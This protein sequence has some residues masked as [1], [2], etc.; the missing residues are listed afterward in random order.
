MSWRIGDSDVLAGSLT[1]GAT[2]A[3]N[4]RLT[5]AGDAAPA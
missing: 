5:L 3:W 1:H 2:G 4:A